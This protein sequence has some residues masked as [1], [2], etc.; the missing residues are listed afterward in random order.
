[1]SNFTAWLWT[2][3][4]IR[5]V[6]NRIFIWIGALHSTTITLRW[7]PSWS[8][9]SYRHF[10]WRI[11]CSVSCTTFTRATSR[12]Y[13]A[14]YLRSMYCSYWPMFDRNKCDRALSWRIGYCAVHLIWWIRRAAA[15]STREHGSW[16]SDICALPIQ[17]SKW[18]FCSKFSMKT[19]AARLVSF[20]WTFISER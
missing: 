7:S 4:C 14:T 20:F 10:S 18:L 17:K 16:C 19:V 9:S 12:Y 15:S 13:L 1:M 3:W 2:H 11:C 6:T 8:T 5:V